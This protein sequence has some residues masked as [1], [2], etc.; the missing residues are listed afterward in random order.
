MGET[1]MRMIRTSLS[2]ALAACAVVL[3]SAAPTNTNTDAVKHAQVAGTFPETELTAAVMSSSDDQESSAT[4]A[5]P[6][7]VVE[8]DI[9]VHVDDRADLQRQI[10]ELTLQ[11]QELH[12]RLASR[13]LPSTELLQS[14]ARAGIGL[15]CQAGK[16][17]CII[18]DDTKTR[19][20]LTCHC[21]AE[22]GV[23]TADRKTCCEGYT[24]NQRDYKYVAGWSMDEAKV[25]ED[26]CQSHRQTMPNQEKTMPNQEKEEEEKTEDSSDPCTDLKP[27]SDERGQC[28]KDHF[29]PRMESLKKKLTS[30]SLRTKECHTPPKN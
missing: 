26:V 1:T 6:S 4:G 30:Y 28:C 10:Q 13:A 8:E 29:A 3:C 22:S 9:A 19:M 24:E 5:N 11:N 27:G 23:S 20:A 7:D 17:K 14:K 25:M 2:V 16:P 12:K 15:T 21:A 18:D